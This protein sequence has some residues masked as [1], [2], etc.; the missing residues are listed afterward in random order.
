[1]RECTV[2]GCASKIWAKG[3]CSTHYQ[4]WKDG[5]DLYAPIRS[6]QPTVCTVDGCSKSTLAKKFCS[7]HY[8]RF[9]K[10]G[11]PLLGAQKDSHVIDDSRLQ[12]DICDEVKAKDEFYLRPNGFYK[13]TCKICDKRFKRVE[14]LKR[15]Y[16]DDALVIDDR[17]Q[18]GE[19]C[20]ICGKVTSKMVVDHCHDTGKVSGLLCNAHNIGIGMFDD[21]PELLM[22]A[23]EYLVR[24]R[25]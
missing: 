14:R 6:K 23:Y 15:K 22:K 20:E 2:D 18:A 16:G 10:W 17:I 13:R 3:Y 9:V 11:D 24:T 1:M 19:G 8:E 25:T 12:C 21:N 5:R 7:M 4:R